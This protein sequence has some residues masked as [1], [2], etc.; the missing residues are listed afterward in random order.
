MIRTKPCKTCGEVIFSINSTCEQV[1]LICT[2]CN[3]VTNVNVG[4]YSTLEKKCNECSNEYFKIKIHD[5]N[6][7]K[8]RIGI[9]CTNCKGTPKYYYIDKDGKLI[10]R[11]SRE[12]LI[13]QD[14]IKLVSN[15]V[16][17][18]ESRIDNIEHNIK[19]VELDLF[20]NLNRKV[21][22]NKL[23][24]NSINY[25]VSSFSDELSKLKDMI[26]NIEKSIIS[27][28]YLFK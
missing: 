21:N 8:E 13:I 17:N 28:L 19:H 10:D 9:E 15:N 23:D 22:E 20:E 3:S 6:K 12:M 26:N 14:T 2:N 4:K 27:S 11:S 24:I 7:N 25:E 1:E 16:N 5:E 18:L